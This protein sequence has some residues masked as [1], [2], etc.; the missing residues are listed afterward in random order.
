M[1]RGSQETKVWLTVPATSENNPHKRIARVKKAM[2]LTGAIDSFFLEHGINPHDQALRITML[3]DFEWSKDD[4]KAWLALAQRA[5]VH[6]PS[7]DTIAIV[8]AHF[9]ARVRKPLEKKVLQ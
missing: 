8:R 4:K 2:A 5:Q 1:S 6:P 9:A 3:I 7:D